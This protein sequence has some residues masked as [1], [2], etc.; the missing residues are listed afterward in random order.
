MKFSCCIITLVLVTFTNAAPPNMAMHRNGFPP[1]AP[2][3]NPMA[4]N[5]VDPATGYYI[6][7]ATIPQPPPQAQ[8]A[9]AVGQQKDVFAY[10]ATI[11]VVGNMLAKSSPQALEYVGKSMPAT[12]ELPEVEDS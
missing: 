5:Q 11:P 6:M 4:V 9:G 3:T 7:P 1:A 10:I 12:I 2:A 8:A